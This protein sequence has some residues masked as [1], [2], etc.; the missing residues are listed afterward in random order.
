VSGNINRVPQTEN[1]VDNSLK[2]NNK[3]NDVSKDTLFIC[4]AILI[5]ATMICYFL[6]EIAINV[7]YP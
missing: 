5:A 6:R 3:T 4:G 1:S 7:L 2:V